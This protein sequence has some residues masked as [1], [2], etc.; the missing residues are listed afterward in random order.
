LTVSQEIHLATDE[1]LASAFRPPP[2]H[3]LW[4][5]AEANIVLTPKTGTFSPGP[6][7]TRH[8]PHIREVMESFRDPDTRELV[9]AFGA[10][11]GK[12]LME[13]ICCAW[14][15]DNDPGNS[16]FVM[17]SE[18]MAKSFSKSRLQQVITDCSVTDVHTLSGRGTFNLLEM[19]LDNC[20]IA[21]AG[22]GSASNL[23]SRPI[24]YLYLDELDKYPPSLGEEGAPEDLAIERT[25]TFP[26]SKVVKSST[27]TTE[28]APIWSSY[29]QSDRREWFCPCPKCGHRFVVKWGRVKFPKEE[30]NGKHLSDDERAERCYVSCPEC[31]HRIYESSRRQFLA[32]GQWHST[33]KAVPGIVGYRI[34]EV[35]SCIGRS[36]PKLVKLF[37]SAERKAKAGNFESLRTF[38]CSVLAEPW[39]M[40]TD[41]M[42]DKGVIEQ[43]Q[44]DYERGIVPTYLP[45]A[46]LTMGIDTQDNGFYYTVRAWGGGEAMESWGIDSGFCESLADVERVAFSEFVGE[47]GQKF[48]ISGGFIDSQ[49]HRT[50]EIYDWCRTSGR[51]VRILPAK[52][53]RNLPGGNPYTYSIIDKDG[54]GKNMIGGMQLCRINTTF[55]KDWLDSKLR[56]PQEDPGAWHVFEGVTEDYCR[57]MV[58]EYRNED[59]VWTPRSARAANHYWD[60][61]VLSLARA[62]SLQLNR[63]VTRQAKAPELGARVRPQRE[64]RW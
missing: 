5:W 39:R 19:E 25:K 46:G 20:V 8:T 9:L 30:E 31:D 48:S 4:E 60:C 52:G 59:G 12:T 44:A 14:T 58:S 40:N 18:Q 29:Q 34:S 54:R 43:C 37:L 17:P 61:E 6:Y 62:A 26:N 53:E 10:Q 41:T 45:V 38:I 42:R 33:A 35:S 49:G 11:T 28:D 1:A 3:K 24:R 21:L 13:T 23:A 2:E 36:W 51:M 15:I 57:Q 32:S 50:S 47:N 22:A 27:I 63:H 56:V 64:R 55:F 7:R 16:L